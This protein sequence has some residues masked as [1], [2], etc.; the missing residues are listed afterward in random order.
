M[1]L[2]NIKGTFKTLCL[3]C[4]S[5]RGVSS[6]LLRVFNQKG[7][8]NG[9]TGKVVPLFDVKYMSVMMTPLKNGHEDKKE[10]EVQQR[11]SRPKLSPLSYSAPTPPT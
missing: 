2:V 6:L 10:S 7:Q 4:L 3:G 11:M 1:T 5:I 8:H 9:A